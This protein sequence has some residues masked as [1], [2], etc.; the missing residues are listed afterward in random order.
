MRSMRSASTSLI[1]SSFAHVAR[2]L[3]I[4]RVPVAR[5]ALCRRVRRLYS[6]PRERSS[7]RKRAGDRRG[8]DQ[9]HRDAIAE[10]VGLAAAVAD[11][12]VAVLVIAEIVVA[13]GARRDEAV[14]AGVV[15]LDEQAGAGH[16]GDAALERRADAIGEE[17]REQPVEG[18]AL[19]LHGAA[20]GGRDLR[21]DLAQRRGVLLRRQRAVA[22]PQVRG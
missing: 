5:V 9:P 8:L 19:R 14:G 1:V 12:R 4:G 6:G 3:R 16:A 20:L 17:M 10:P 7:N 13:D 22:E 15:E 2:D 11:Q 21:A 18:L